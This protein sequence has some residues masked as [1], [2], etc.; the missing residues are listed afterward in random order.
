MDDHQKH[1]EAHSSALQK[2][3]DKRMMGMIRRMQE[4]LYDNLMA[5]SK[6]NIYHTLLKRGYK[7]TVSQML[8]D[9]NILKTLDNHG[10]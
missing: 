9:F 8:E 10:N 1:L 5:I 2:A 6:S 7:G 4:R 3:I